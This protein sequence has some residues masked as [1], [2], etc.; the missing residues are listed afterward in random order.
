MATPRKSEPVDVEAEPSVIDALAEDAVP[1]DYPEGAPLL[2]PHLQ[3]R[4]RSR[5]AEFKRKFAELNKVQLKLQEI[6]QSGALDSEDPADNLRLGADL[7]DMYQQMDDLLRLAA[8]NPDHYG[9]WS[10]AVDDSGLVG[11]FN[12]Y[13]RR[14]QPGEASGSAS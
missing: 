3:I 12:V 9:E 14:T 7:D 8:V 4:P 6:R 1:E 13:M 2:L 5:R 10:D 11:V